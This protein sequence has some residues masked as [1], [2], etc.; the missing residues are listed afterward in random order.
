MIKT[1]AILA[2]I[3][4]LGLASTFAADATGA[5]AKCGKTSCSSCSKCSDGS[6]PPAARVAAS[7]T[8]IHRGGSGAE[9]AFSR[10]LIC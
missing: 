5:C 9:K 10:P 1:G 4:G 6:A 3:A 2:L 8:K 7:E